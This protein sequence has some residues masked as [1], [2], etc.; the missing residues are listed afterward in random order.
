MDVHLVDGTYELFRFFH[1]VPSAKDDD[2]RELGAVRAIV[3]SIL[4]MISGGATHVAVA[5]DHIIESFRNELWEGYKTGAGIEPD[6]RAQFTPL[7][8]ALAAAGIVVWPMIELEADDAL[9]A[10]AEAA[11]RDPRVSR[12]IICTPDKDLAQSVRGTRVVQLNRRTR[13]I[14]DEA[15]V[16]KKFGVPPASI[17][18]YLALV[19]DAADGYPGLPGWGAKSSA[20][21]LAKFGHIESI[22]PNAADWHVNAN[23]ATAL[24]RTLVERREQALLF[25][26]L[27]TLRTDFDLFK[28][29]DELE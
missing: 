9:A 5:T 13:E 16:V 17:P 1:A 3:G 21:V 22:P 15:G 26:T 12:V 7:E 29:V 2:R 27:A 10:G 4:G 19:G 11:A 8:E 24:A 20:A 14:R 28:S 6:L 23:N 25:R 18:D